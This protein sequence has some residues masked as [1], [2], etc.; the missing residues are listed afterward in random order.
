LYYFG[1]HED[2]EGLILNGFFYFDTKSLSNRSKNVTKR[3]E[4]DFY[5]ITMI[6][7]AT[8][9]RGIMGFTARPRAMMA[10]QGP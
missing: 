3:S 10:A 7:Y 5:F 4:I 1:Q 9:A 6:H 2:S 8:P